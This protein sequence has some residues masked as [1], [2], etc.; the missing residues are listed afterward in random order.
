VASLSDV[1]EPTHTEVLPEVASSG[2]TVTTAV[3][4]HPPVAV[5]VIIVVPPA[6]PVTIPVVAPTVPA[7]V[8][9]LLQVPD[10]VRSDK[11]VDDPAQTVV[12]P[13]IDEGNAFTVTTE[14]V[15]LQPVPNV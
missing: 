14:A 8:L 5:K 3:I 13:R 12:V 10:P 11:V 15:V 2:L 6:I 4:L 1:V 7:A 9:L